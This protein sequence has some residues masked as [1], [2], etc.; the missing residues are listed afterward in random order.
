MS[1]TTT[2]SSMEG[3]HVLVLF[4]KNFLVLL[5]FF[6]LLEKGLATVLIGSLISVHVQVRARMGELPTGSLHQLS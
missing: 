5:A 1:E 6:F 4:F 2:N 3:V